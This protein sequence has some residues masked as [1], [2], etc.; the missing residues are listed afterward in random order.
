ME[1]HPFNTF[2]SAKRNLLFQPW[3]FLHYTTSPFS[4]PETA[5]VKKIEKL[6]PW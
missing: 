1:A 5:E 6:S 4:D 2:N 3:L